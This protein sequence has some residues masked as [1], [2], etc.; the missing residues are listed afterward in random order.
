VP[1]GISRIMLRDL[2]Q[3]PGGVYLVEVNDKMAGTT[4]Q[5]LIKNK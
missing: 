5:K 2:Q 4:Y 1:K 3:L